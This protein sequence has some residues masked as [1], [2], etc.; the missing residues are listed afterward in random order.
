[1]RFLV[2]QGSRAKRTILC[3]LILSTSDS[4]KY[5]AFFLDGSARPQFHFCFKTAVYH[6]GVDCTWGCPFIDFDLGLSSR[7]P[8]LFCRWWRNSSCNWTGKSHLFS[9]P[10]Y[11]CFL[12]SGN[13]WSRIR[14]RR[15]SR[16]L[17]VR[18]HRMFI[19]QKKVIIIIN[20]IQNLCTPIRRRK[21]NL[22]TLYEDYVV[23]R[24]L[25]Y[26]SR[27]IHTG[28]GRTRF[29]CQVFIEK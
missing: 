12:Y 29:S 18:L 1:M 6:G 10:I 4:I 26:P 25:L 19:L 20:G 15:K 21:E 3:N 17:I 9:T 22:A 13:R 7:A 23:V 8:I 28:L 27:I 5:L 24:N 16:I 11:Y 2:L 14:R